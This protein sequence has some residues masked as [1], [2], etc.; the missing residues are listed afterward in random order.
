MKNLKRVLGLLLSLVLM[1]S[2]IPTITLAEEAPT[3]PTA[4]ITEIENDELTF[5]MNFL[6]DMPTQEQWDYYGSWYA[7]F[8][9]TVNKTVTFNADG[10][11]DGWL[12][13]QYDGW[14]EA[15]VS[16][17]FDDVTLQAGQ[18]LKIMEFAAE[19]TGETG[20]KLTYA[21]VCEGVQDFNCG[22]FFDEEF[23]AANPDLEVTL[24]LK[25]YNPA[26]ESESYVVGESF[27]F[28][29]APELPTA[30]VTETE[31][32]DL[33]FS[34]NFKVDEATLAQQAYYGKWYADFE[35]TVNKTVVFNNDGSA[36]G[37]LAGQYDEWSENWVTVP[38]GK[39]APVT[40]EAGET[41]KIM[42]F[43][44]ELMGEPGLK[45][46]FQ[47]VYDVVKDF[48]CGVFFDTEFLMANPDL[49]VTLELKMYNPAD[50]T[51]NYV[52]GETYVFTNSFVAQNTAT[53]KLYTT[54]TEAM[55]DCATGE[56]V[57]LLQDASEFSIT[58]LENTTLDLNGYTLT[59]AYVSSFGD[60]I[61]SSADN[62]GLLV[63]PANRIFMQEDNAQLPVYIGTG[64]RFIEVLQIRT[65]ILNGNEFAFAPYFEPAMQEL[66][67]GSST[68]TGVT[69]EVAVSWKQKDGYRTQRFVFNDEFV[70][71]YIDSYKPSTGHYGKMFS[72][73]LKNAENYEELTFTAMIVSKTNVTF[74]K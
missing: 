55:L 51:E 50:E 39:Y 40:V 8:E 24:E 16:V 61:D 73:T 42:A 68:S 49:V 52:I 6:V 56:T 26:D 34:M 28:D 47:E 74:T 64:Y 7:D 10:N 41:I 17:P 32:N 54:V 45:Y 21:D 31:N 27:V 63:V 3:L 14:S 38:F 35:L 59:A 72:L 2:C 71:G 43:A 62:T 46:T 53:N 23:L 33:T 58:V 5:A 19:M 13:G 20:L 44:A 37:W 70:Q 66:L 15:W 48:D 9:L 12:S 22:V 67:M 25:M 1:L 65:A 69:I 30:T 36:D 18:T 57:V 29:T 60:I 11:A 4:T